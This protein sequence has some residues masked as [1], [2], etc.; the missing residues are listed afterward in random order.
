[1]TIT[2]VTNLVL[3][4]LLN[5]RISENKRRELELQEKLATGKE[6]N[7][8]QDNPIGASR[9]LQMEATLSTL[10]Q[11]LRNMQRARA[12]LS[13]SET[14]LNSV[15][16]VLEEVRVTAATLG[17]PA[18]SPG[19][20]EVA[21][22]LVQGCIDQLVQL[23]NTRFGNIYIFGGRETTSPPFDAVG[24]YGGDSAEIEVSIGTGHTEVI[25]IPGDV[26]F[27]GAGGGE[28]VFDILADL[29]S[30]LLNNSPDEVRAAGARLETAYQ[31]V[32]R[33]ISIL[34][35]RTKQLDIAETSISDIRFNVLRLQSETSDADLAEVAT[36]FQVQMDASEAALLAATR[37]LGV[38]L[39]D[40]LA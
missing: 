10:D 30:A 15:L 21:A 28:D 39:L 25:N 8:P 31:Q 20:R 19:D 36:Q 22:S 32:N 27:K 35:S 17:E 33:S 9:M 11:Y 1:M 14:A 18:V 4:T 13:T 7:R 29:K 23:G 38:S 40:F 5:Q 6:I 2:R 26:P 37:M 34:G 24:G 16:G 3:L 12:S